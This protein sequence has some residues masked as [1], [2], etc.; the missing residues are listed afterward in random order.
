MVSKTVSN[1]VVSPQQM[2]LDLKMVGADIWGTKAHVLM[3]HKSKII[4]KK[5]AADILQALAEIERS[6]EEGEFVIDPSRG[7]QLTLEKEI[8]ERAGERS[9]LSAHTARSRNDQVMVT[10]LIFLREEVCR[11]AKQV[12][13]VA[14]QLLDV[15]EK[16]A[17]WV[18]PGYTHMQPGKPTTVAHWA[19]SFFGGFLR[20]HQ[21]LC[22][23]LERYDRCPLGSV[24]SFGTSWPI[25]RDYTASL[26]G[27]ADVWEIPLDAIGHRGVFQYELLQILSLGAIE[28]SKIATD[29]L[30]Y[31]TF[32]YGYFE[33]GDDVAQRL[34][35]IT[36]SSVMAQKRNPDALELLRA[37]GNQLG[38]AMV[39]GFELLS[40]LPAGYNRDSRELK[41]YVEL[42]MRKFTSGL[43]VLQDVLKSGKFNRERME[44][45]VRANYSLTTDVADFVSQTTGQ[46]YRLVYK[47]VGK[48]V[49]ELMEK[50][51]SL[52]KLRL[53]RLQHFASEFDVSLQIDEEDLKKVLQPKEAISRR[54]HRGGA[55]PESI[56]A[57]LERLKQMVGE[58]SMKIENRL[59]TFQSA[60]ELTAREAARVLGGHEEASV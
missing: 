27:F 23:L 39:A 45:L 2:Q 18:M 60:R 57:S 35:P 26:L 33:L 41:E 40:G 16:H 7:A 17:D 24:E 13:K 54:K 15:A 10:E 56:A 20:V 50:G 12:E 47:I 4:P 5:C 44:E 58:A 11:L 38:G 8:V 36:G 42:G 1:F 30:Q 52:E 48:A 43:K 46:P 22:G 21:A 53:D 32:E 55:A 6:F 9:G 3:L 37:S 25:D 19:L 49:D 34:H 31:A 29:T 59:A 28:L 51:L 14:A